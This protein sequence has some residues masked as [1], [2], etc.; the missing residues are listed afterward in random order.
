VSLYLDASVLV[1]LFVIE[2]GECSGGGLL[3]AHPAIV[4]TSDFGAAE[5]SSA[6]ARRTRPGDRYAPVED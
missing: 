5:L 3:S 6:V 4:I 2:P 1:A